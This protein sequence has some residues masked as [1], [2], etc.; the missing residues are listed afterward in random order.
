[1]ASTERHPWHTIV[2]PAMNFSKMRPQNFFQFRKDKVTVVMI[3]A[4]ETHG[5]APQ[6][7]M[8]LK[9]QNREGLSHKN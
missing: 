6:P 9:I 5:D 8:V 7:R 4:V 2:F 1:M 3:K